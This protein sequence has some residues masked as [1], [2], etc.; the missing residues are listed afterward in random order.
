MKILNRYIIKQFLRPFFYALLAFVGILLLANIFEYLRS[1]LKNNVPFFTAF[2]FFFYT[3]P[4]LIVQVIPIAVLLGIIFCLNQLTKNRELMIMKAGGLNIR[5]IILPL[6]YSS[7]IISLGVFTMNELF[8]PPS[9]KKANTLRLNEIEKSSVHT[10]YENISFKYGNQFF[11]VKM[12]DS[13]NKKMQVLQIIEQRIDKTVSVRID[14][15]LGSWKKYE[16]KYE[17]TLFDGI[18]RKFNSAGEIQNME[19]FREKKLL[20]KFSPEDFKEINPEEMNLV[21]LF[22]YIESLKESGYYPRDMLVDFYNKILFPFASF[23]IT[24]AGI[25]FALRS[26]RSGMA[27]GFGMSIAISFLYWVSMSLGL[28]WGKAGILPPPIAPVL[29]NLICLMLGTYLMRKI[30]T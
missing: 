1:L 2:R 21:N 10:T 14:A 20:I 28:A 25:P 4:P 9:T 15:H 18:T 23:F 26:K 16:N 22:S 8:I 24:L 11:Y 30:H 5:R 3:T 17:W 12:Y 29:P 13:Q 27:T 6:L 19:K 7:L